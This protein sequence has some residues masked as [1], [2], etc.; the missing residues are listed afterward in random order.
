MKPPRKIF[1]LVLLLMT[2]FLHA[3]VVSEPEII[4]SIPNGERGFS[5]VRVPTGVRVVAS[6]FDKMGLYLYTVITVTKI[7]V[8]T[9]NARTAA[10]IGDHVVRT[11]GSEENQNT[12]ALSEDELSRSVIVISYSVGSFQGMDVQRDYYFP[13]VLLC[14]TEANQ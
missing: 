12:F 14:K 10:T 4:T 7:T 2:P 13:T 6:S 9:A 3:G 5:I 1:T 8:T 11:E